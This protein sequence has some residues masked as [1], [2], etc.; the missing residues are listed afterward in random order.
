VLPV[1][2]DATGPVITRAVG[3]TTL[4][5]L[6]VTFD[7]AVADSAANPANFSIAGLTVTGATL[8]AGNKDVALTTS[9]QTAS[10]VYTVNVSGVRDR[11]PSGNLILAGASANFTGYSTPAI[12]AGVAD[13]AGYDLVYRLAIPTASPAWNLNTIPYSVDEAKYG[14]RTFDRVAYLMELDGNWVYASFDRHTNALSKIGVPTLG[15]TA[16]AFQQIVKNMNVASNVGTITTG[17]GIATGNIEFWGG[18]YNAANGI[19]IPNGSATI[20]DFGDTMSVGAYGSMQIH[21]H[22]ASQVLMAYNN[23][24]SSVGQTSE[25]GIGNHPTPSATSSGAQLDWTFSNNS[26][27]FTVRNLYV[28]ARPG[29]TPTGTAPLVIANPTSR[30]VN[31]GAATTFAVQASGASSFQWRKNGTPIVGATQPW[32]DLTGITASDAGS[33]DVV[34][35]GPTLVTTT[36]LAATLSL[37]T[38][39]TFAGYTVFAQRNVAVGTA[40]STILTRASDAQGDTISLNAVSATSTSGGTL[41]LGAGNVNYTPPTGFLG[42]DTFTITL[43]DSMGLSGTGTVNVFVS[44]NGQPPVSASVNFQQNG[45]IAGLFIGIVGQS[46]QVQRSTDLIAWTVLKTVLPAPDGTI[47]LTDLAPPSSKAFYRIKETP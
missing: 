22:G 39:P 7:E 6:V 42:N 44:T 41:S 2:S 34:L 24:G 18:N 15:V 11:S 26:T 36:S 20:Y 28:L 33:Y 40:V 16:T 45:S 19:A 32:L 17:T 13:A 30:I 27:T 14:E 43:T 23:W 35:R 37:N 31:P 21:N 9:V 47:P 8:L 1:N 10:T 12:V 29:G 38:A 46:Y 25:T 5:R 3:S 4:N